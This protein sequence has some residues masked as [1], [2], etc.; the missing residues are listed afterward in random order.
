MVKDLDRK[1]ERCSGEV[2]DF[3]TGIDLFCGR[4]SPLL[5]DREVVRDLEMGTSSD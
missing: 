5:D 2:G 1:T 4:I 3:F